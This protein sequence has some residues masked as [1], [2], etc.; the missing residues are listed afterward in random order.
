MDDKLFEDMVVL[1]GALHIAT[2]KAVLRDLEGWQ[3]R[4]I[5]TT[6]QAFYARLRMAQVN[7]DIREPGPLLLALAQFVKETGA[8]A[9]QLDSFLDGYAGQ[10]WQAAKDG[11]GWAGKSDNLR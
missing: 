5:E 9:A 3:G 1:A 6:R 4:E 10:E 2:L 8:A 7:Q 11:A